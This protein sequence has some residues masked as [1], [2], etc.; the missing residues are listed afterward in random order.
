MHKLQCLNISKRFLTGCFMGTMSQLAS[1]SYWRDSFQDQ[2][3]VAFRDQLLGNV[4]HESQKSQHAG[5]ML[6][7]L[8][9]D[10]L[11]VFRKEK[12]RIKSNMVAK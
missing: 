7:S 4:L 10:E 3:T 6:D 11:K 12:D 9:K 2:L 1:H 5:R 8:V